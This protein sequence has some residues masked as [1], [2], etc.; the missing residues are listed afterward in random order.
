[1]DYESI[2]QS[3]ILIDDINLKIMLN[4]PEVTRQIKNLVVKMYTD[5]LYV[6]KLGNPVQ[7]NDFAKEYKK[8]YARDRK[9]LLTYFKIMIDTF[10]IRKTDHKRFEKYYN[11]VK[12]IF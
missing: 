10:K 11:Y 7:E 2:S 8:A 4:D 1:M 12:K 5:K 9:E 3:F 6:D